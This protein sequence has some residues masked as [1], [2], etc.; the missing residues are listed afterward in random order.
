MTRIEDYGLLISA[1]P[2]VKGIIPKLHASDLG[3]DKGLSK[4]K[5]GQKVTGRVLQVDSGAR[6]LTLTLKPGLLGSRLNPLASLAQASPG[7]RAHGVIAGVKDFGLFVTFY[8]GLSGLLHSSQLGIEEGGKPSEAGYSVG[9]VIKVA[10]LAVEP[11]TGRLKL[12][13]LTS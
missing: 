3:A 2:N 4:F 10:V 13:E 8:G 6:K 1:G 12:G 11:G 5:I 7:L 9:Q